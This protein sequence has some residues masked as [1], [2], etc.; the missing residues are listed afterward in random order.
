MIMKHVF[1]IAS[2]QDTSAS[3]WND[4]VVEIMSKWDGTDTWYTFI[5]IYCDCDKH[6]LM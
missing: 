4:K 3:K 1:L 6:S 5:M 2:V